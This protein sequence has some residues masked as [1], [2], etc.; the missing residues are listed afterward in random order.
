VQGDTIHL[1]RN[2]FE[3]ANVNGKPK[4]GILKDVVLVNGFK[5]IEFDVTSDGWPDVIPLPPPTPYGL[6]IQAAV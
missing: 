2:S 4:A 5:K 1:H 3:L 6:R